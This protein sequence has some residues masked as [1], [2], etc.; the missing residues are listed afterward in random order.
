M[1]TPLSNAK[2]MCVLYLL[3]CLDQWGLDQPLG[4]RC[5]LVFSAAQSLG[6]TSSEKW[7]HSFMGL[8]QRLVS[9]VASHLLNG[10]SG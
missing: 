4:H 6:L 7:P 3:S 10:G 2:C 8:L 5:G 1:V 9:R